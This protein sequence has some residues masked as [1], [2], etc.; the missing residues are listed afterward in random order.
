MS[1]SF[2]EL[3]QLTR[4]AVTRAEELQVPIVISIVDAN[5]T[6]MV[7]WRMPDAQDHGES[8]R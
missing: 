5:G 8:D 1:L 2:Q 6:Q 3:H 4:A 7:T